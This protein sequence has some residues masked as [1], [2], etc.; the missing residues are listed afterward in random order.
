MSIIPDWLKI[1]S[2]DDEDDTET[3]FE[4]QMSETQRLK[5]SHTEKRIQLNDL[6]EE[7][8]RAKQHG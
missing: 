2:D 3:K 6:L 1:V 5:Q 4:E 7:I 8:K